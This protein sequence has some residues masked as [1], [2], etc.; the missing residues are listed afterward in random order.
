MY[1]SLNSV[2]AFVIFLS[3]Y[4]AVCLRCRYPCEFR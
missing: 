2:N 4:C 3:R 1:R